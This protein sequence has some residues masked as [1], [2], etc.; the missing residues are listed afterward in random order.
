MKKVNLKKLIKSMSFRDKAKLVLA[1]AGWSIPGGESQLLTSSEKNAIL[2]DCK[3]KG[4]IDELHRIGKLSVVMYLTVLE[5]QNIFNRLQYTIVNLNFLLYLM[6]SG[7]LEEFT[8][9]DGNKQP[10]IAL[11]HAFLDVFDAYKHL[12]AKLFSLNFIKRK[13]NDIDLLSE[14]DQKITNEASDEISSF[15]ENAFLYMLGIYKSYMDAGDFSAENV[16]E[17]KFLELIENYKKSL[18][19][20]EDEQTEAIKKLSY[21]RD[22]LS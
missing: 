10:L 14:K 20:T 16:S 12:Y 22:L 7:E 13:A 4:E 8:I 5:T 19:F 1:D 9:N 18:V 15:E 21:M 17:S 6:G 11:Q 2:Q 3:D